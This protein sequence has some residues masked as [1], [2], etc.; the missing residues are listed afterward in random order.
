[1]VTQRSTAAMSTN[2]QFPQDVAAENAQYLRE[3][4]E[5]KHAEQ[6]LKEH[7]KFLASLNKQ[8]SSATALLAEKTLRRES[9]LRKHSSSKNSTFRRFLCHPFI[10]RS[11]ILNEANYRSAL[12]DE[13]AAKTTLSG[14]E[15][16]RKEATC[17]KN[18]LHDD[19]IRQSE[20][21]IDLDSLH[22]DIFSVLPVQDRFPS[23]VE[24]TRLLYQAQMDFEEMKSQTM[25]ARD[26][27]SQFRRAQSTV[28]KTIAQLQ[29]Q[30]LPSPRSAWRFDA[31]IYGR[32]EKH[33]ENHDLE[34]IEKQVLH[35]KDLVAYAYSLDATISSQ[36]PLVHFKEPE[37]TC[38]CPCYADLIVRFDLVLE[39]ANWRPRRLQNVAG[40]QLEVVEK[41]LGRVIEMALLKEEKVRVEL[42]AASSRVEEERIQLR[43]VRSEI[44][45]DGYEYE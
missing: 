2:V 5:T 38:S 29:A 45:L 43:T 39:K 8:I 18:E 32:R 9:A 19:I 12:S 1:M 15:Q 41:V 31:S 26:V 42:A 4:A 10:I 20:A 44:V 40:K 30:R 11:T 37:Q 25:S 33:T 24:H 7:T 23:E 34:K 21:T 22:G 28:Q 27:V 16:M 17:H 6:A 35:A 14:L 13:K 36:A 3:I